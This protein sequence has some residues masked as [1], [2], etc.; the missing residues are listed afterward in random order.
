MKT[1]SGSKKKALI[2]SIVIFHLLFFA[3]PGPLLTVALIVKD[4]LAGHM[5]E[6]AKILDARFPI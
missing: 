2:K 5:A 1:P 6:V 4:T 3:I